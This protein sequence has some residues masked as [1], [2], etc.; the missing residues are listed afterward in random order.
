MSSQRL[1]YLD[2]LKVLLAILIVTVHVALAYAPD[3]WWFFKGGPENSDL[4][5]YYQIVNPIAMALFFLLSAYFLP[6]S[7]DRKGGRVF[8]KERLKRIGIPFILGVFLII[9]PLHFLYHT[10]FRDCGYNSIWEY[11]VT[12]FFGIGGDP[13]MCHDPWLTVWPDLKVAHLWFLQHLIIYAVV[14]TIIRAIMRRSQ[15]KFPKMSV[16]KT[17]QIMLFIIGMSLVTFAVRVSY[18]LDYWD[19]FLGA[20]QVEYANVPKYIV[21]FIIGIVAYRAKWIEQFPTFHG[22]GWLT[23]GVILFLGSLLAQEQLS[24][25]LAPGGL[26]WS[27]FL[28][29]LWDCSMCTSL[30]I[31]LLVLFREVLNKSGTILRMMSANTYG[32]YIFHV[33]IV[34][35]I[36]YV[37]AFLELPFALTVILEM[38]IGVILSFSVSFFIRQFKWLRTV[39]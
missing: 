23:V 3:I 13:G 28:W 14:Y 20:I 29:S 33:P 24:F 37:I 30:A 7:Y 26:N 10:Q 31:G 2:N 4:L 32:V 35:L 38:V 21:F 17:Y 11:T 9:I 16:P 15:I 34:A 8:L 22:F 12:M 1:Y 5:I 18:P 25:I 6:Y 39:L 19:G 36:Q 27:S